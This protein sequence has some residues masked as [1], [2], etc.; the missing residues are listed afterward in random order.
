MGMGQAVRSSALCCPGS[1]AA[2]P[3]RNARPGGFQRQRAPAATWPC[4][5][6]QVYVARGGACCVHAGTTSA[7][8]CGVRRPGTCPTSVGAE[9][10]GKG[11]RGCLSG[12]IGPL[13]RGRG[14][15]RQPAARSQQPPGRHSPVCVGPAADQAGACGRPVNDLGPG[16]GDGA[17]VTGPEAKPRGRAPSFLG[18][19]AACA[20]IGR[21]PPARETGEPA[22]PVPRD[23]PKNL[24]ASRMVDY[25]ARRPGS[26]VKLARG[27]PGSMPRVHRAKAGE[28]AR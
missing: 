20:A 10:L 11:L 16:W 18:R 25:R 6:S 4:V 23:R 3:L 9:A 27:A 24:T 5:L 8:P 7:R 26:C 2:S 19:P 22:A 1:G 15:L 17:P 13:A 12:R 21:R 14:F 28:H